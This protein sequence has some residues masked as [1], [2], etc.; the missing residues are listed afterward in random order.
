MQFGEKQFSMCLGL[1]RQKGSQLQVQHT[2][3]LTS[4]AGSTHLDL[5]PESEILQ[6]MVGLGRGRVI[7]VKTCLVFIW[8]GAQADR[9][10]DTVQPELSLNGS[11][12]MAWHGGDT[13]WQCTK[14]TDSAFQLRVYSS[15][16]HFCQCRGHLTGSYAS[17]SCSHRPN[18]VCLLLLLSFDLA[19]MVACM[20][21]RLS[22]FY[23]CK[24]LFR[25]MVLIFLSRSE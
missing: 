2:Y 3:S 22:M 5:G 9:A 25:D 8:D 19:L 4:Y 7:L 24:I 18:E 1:F 11:G 17:R 15:E 23:D 12:S 13:R 14:T 10:G 16:S 6:Q 21:M 20:G